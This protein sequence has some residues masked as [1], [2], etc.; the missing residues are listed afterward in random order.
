[1]PATQRKR[2]RNEL[3]ALEMNDAEVRRLVYHPAAFFEPVEPRS[4]DHFRSNPMLEINQEYMDMTR[5]GASLVCHYP[6]VFHT[7]K[8]GVDSSP[9]AI[10]LRVMVPERRMALR[11]IEE[12]QFDESEL[13]SCI[14]LRK[15]AFRCDYCP[16]VH[17]SMTWIELV[18]FGLPDILCSMSLMYGTRLSTIW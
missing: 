17:A 2:S 4:R 3:T 1:M 18:S 8:R 7:C 5:R 11:I 15:S 9:R 6:T 16:M 10:E 14:A 13:R 12:C